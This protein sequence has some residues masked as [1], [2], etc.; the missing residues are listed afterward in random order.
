MP[1]TPTENV[2]AARLKQELDALGTDPRGPRADL[3]SR[4]MQAG[5]YEINTSVPP[6]QPKIDRVS[7]FPNHSSVLI[8]NGAKLEEHEDDKLLIC[9]DSKREPLISGDFKTETV[10]IGKCLGLKSNDDFGSHISGV[11]GDLRRSGSALYM[12]R[13]SDVH[14]G[15]YPIVFGS[16]VIV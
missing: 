1:I 4:L 5:V 9:N 10:N 12:Y 6:K 7:R 11:E 13:S 3:V 14:P 15:W 8:G 2:G 16:V